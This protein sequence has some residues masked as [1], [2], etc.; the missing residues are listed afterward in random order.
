MHKYCKEN[1][2]IVVAEYVDKAR[3]ATTDQ[4]PDFLRMVDDSN[5]KCFDVVVVHKLDRFSRNRYDSA[6]Y[7]RKL[8][9]NNVKLISVLEPLDDSPESVILEGMLEAFSEYYSKNLSRETMKGLLINSNKCL[10]NGGPSPLGY[11]V[12]DQRLVINQEEAKA[13]QIIFEMTADGFGYGTIVDKL[14]LLGY[15]TKKGQ[16]FGKNSIYEIIRNEKYK[17]V[18]VFNKRASKHNNHAYKPDE[19]VVRIEGGCPAIITKE[20]WERANA[21]RRAS[22]SHYTNAKRTYLLTGL[23]YCE[24]GGKF[25]GNVRRHSKRGL[26]YTTYRCSERVNKRDCD[27][28]EIRCSILDTFIIEKFCEVFFTDESILKITNGLNQNLKIRTDNNDQYNRVKETLSRAETSRDNLIE[29]IIQTGTNEAITAKIKECEAI[30]KEAKIFLD[31]FEKDCSQNT[32]TKNDVIEMIDKLKEYLMNPENIQRS[33]FILSQYIESIRI[34]NETIKATFKVAFSHSYKEDN[35]VVAEYKEEK[36]ISRKLL[37]KNYSDI[38]KTSEIQRII[39]K[40]K[41]RH[42]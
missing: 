30:I 29:A 33:K 10:H 9:Q 28:K 7:K 21:V 41:S 18:Y 32:I 4:R 20:L 26:E 19:E 15:K 3:S 39:E 8:R 23:L 38:D 31:T 36:S 5:D 34:S 35:V 42:E 14:N 2:Y 24:C 37:L 22:R 12:V 25:H 1:G 40:L 17:G 11:D 6:V 27:V 13:V 16:P